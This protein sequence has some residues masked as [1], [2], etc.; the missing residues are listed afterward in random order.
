MPNGRLVIR[1]QTLSS[2]LV[3]NLLVG[4]G[5]LVEMSDGLYLLR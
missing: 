4:D 1:R 3:S 5:A 2:V